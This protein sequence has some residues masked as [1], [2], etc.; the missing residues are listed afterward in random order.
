L[1]VTITDA[2]VDGEVTV[3]LRNLLDDGV[4]C[5]CPGVVVRVSIATP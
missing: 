4:G 3:V 1:G 2:A 5:R